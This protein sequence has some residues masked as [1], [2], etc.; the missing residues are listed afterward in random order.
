MEI[1]AAVIA[2]AHKLRLGVVAEGVEQEEQAEFLKENGCNSAQGF[3][4]GKPMSVKDLYENK[5]KKKKW[6]L[7]Y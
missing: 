1:T 6:K 4:Y 2:M 5:K 7:N 3:F